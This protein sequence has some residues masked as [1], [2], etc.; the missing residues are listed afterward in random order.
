[1]AN[2]YTSADLGPLT[3]IFT[4]P[5]ACISTITYVPPISESG[6]PSLYRGASGNA[7]AKECYPEGFATDSVFSPGICPSG[8]L[9][10]LT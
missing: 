2:L 8:K 3:S 7:I 9:Y 6:S 4:P 5:S 1:M 10:V